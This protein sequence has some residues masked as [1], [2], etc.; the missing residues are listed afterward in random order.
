MA[1]KPVVIVVMAQRETERK[2]T[3]LSGRER[4][5]SVSCSSPTVGGSSSLRSTSLAEGRSSGL[6]AISHPT[7]LATCQ[8]R[9]GLR[10]HS[11]AAA[12]QECSMQK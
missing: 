4:R 6:A 11:S 2:A 5:R 3:H 9:L 7:I 12:R 1:G 8:V 10:A